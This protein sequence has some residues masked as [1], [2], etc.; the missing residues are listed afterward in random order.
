MLRGAVLL[1]GAA[2]GWG[3][4]GDADF[5]DAM[6][7]AVT[8]NADEYRRE[9]T[10][11]DR[12]VFAQGPFDASRRESLGGRLEELARRMKAS[13]DSR[14]I[15]IEVLEVRRLAEVAK[16]APAHPPP[17]ML[18]NQWMRIRAN[19][20]DDRSWFS[21][22]AADLE[23]VAE[24]E[25]SPMPVAAGKPASEAVAAATTGSAA[26]LSTAS[27]LEGRWRVKELSSDG[28]PTHDAELSGALWIFA[29][30][31]LTMSNPTGTSERYTVTRIHDARGSA[32]FLRAR[33]P[34]AG[35][36][37]TGWLIY[38][39]AGETLTVAFHDG[40]GERPE[41]FEAPSGRREPMLV[42]AVLVRADGTEGTP[43]H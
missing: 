12:L 2:C 32:L 18:S 15:A 23:P 29:G 3:C 9:I 10:D 38:E 21:R 7:A 20:F 14:F 34:V 40:L 1:A 33:E 6:P 16:R 43:L 41:G 37:E 25:P 17:Q 36:S 19:V 30:D 4:Q 42:K 11:I 35:G 27:G 26:N 8:L 31:E 39:I 28:K 24:S 22:S 13:S 5:S